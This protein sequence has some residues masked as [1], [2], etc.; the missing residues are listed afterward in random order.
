LLTKLAF[1]REYIRYDD[2]DTIIETSTRGSRRERTKK[3]RKKHVYIL[4]KEEFSAEK[5]GKWMS[6]TEGGGLKRKLEVNF[7]SVPIG[8]IGQLSISIIK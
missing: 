2:I 6:N 5:N 3:E 7:E 1:Q 4:K 8:S